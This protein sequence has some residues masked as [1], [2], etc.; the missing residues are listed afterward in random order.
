M[1]DTQKIT[2][3]LADEDA[4]RRDGLA[5]V[6]RENGGI[7]VLAGCS[8]GETALDEIRDLRPDVAIVD[9]NLPVLHGIELVRRIRGESLGTKIIILSGT[10][11]D[12]IV[13]EVVRAGADAYLLK[14]GP[15]R[16]LTDA[17]SYVRDGGQYFS[18]QLRRDGRDRHLLEEP[19]R[20]P[21]DRNSDASAAWQDEEERLRQDRRA[22]PRTADP[23]RFRERLREETSRKL[24]DRDYDIMAE[25]ADGIRPIL[26]RLDEIED[27]VVE[28]ESGDEPLPADP[29]GW[30]SAQLSDTLTGA[31]STHERGGG[32]VNY[33][34]VEARL[35]E[36]I[37]EAVT[38][39]FQSMAGKLQEE[40]E[41]QH[42]RTLETFVKNIQV[43]LVQRVSVLEQNMQHQ[44]DAMLQLREYNQRT[45][46]NL[47]RLITGVDKLAHELPKRLSAAQ[48]QEA[49]S[50]AAEQPVR[51]SVREASAREAGQ[52]EKRGV[53]HSAFS[54]KKLLPIIFWVL[55]LAG[56]VV[57]VVII[58]SHD[59]DSTTTAA[60]PMGKEIQTANSKA[61]AAPAKPAAAPPVVAGTDTK[62]RLDAAKQAVDRKEYVTAEDIYK[63]VLEAE[64]HNVDALTGLASVL[65]RQDKMEESAAVL[66]RIPKN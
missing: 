10:M 59:N 51:S 41:E 7:E 40:I 22:R 24:R 11:D 32:R 57:A 9:L 8:D 4:L 58:R 29:R 37:E 56:I 5:S 43:K 2:V 53:K 26:D 25:M 34:D 55:V 35:P 30:L 63:Q 14:N 16:H 66:D 60:P 3:L 19:P 54:K 17:I 23:T 15:A 20:I 1:P 27:R 42:V 13:R 12:E 44:A 18:P 31:R 52:K 39:R 50:A 38:K 64:P 48:Q 62:T 65:Y 33:R 46:D 28:M 61:T 6:L 49:E 45:E 21:P 47:S 36:L